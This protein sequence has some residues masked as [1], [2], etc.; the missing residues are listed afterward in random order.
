VSFP[1]VLTTDPA[2]VIVKPVSVGVDGVKVIP[3][4]LDVWLL[5]SIIS[6]DAVNPKLLIVVV[7]PRTVK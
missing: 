7:T 1:V 3:A 4:K 6:I 5:E 2:C